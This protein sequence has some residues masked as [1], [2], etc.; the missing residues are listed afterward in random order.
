MNTHSAPK[1]TA[2]FAKQI[3]PNT[4]PSL[5]KK[6]RKAGSYHKLAEEIEVNVSYIFDLITAGREPNDST[7]R[8]REIRHRLGL[9]KYKPRNR[10]KPKPAPKHLIWWNNIG[11]EMRHAIVEKIYKGKRP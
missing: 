3:D 4:L 11:K 2:R 7:P 5:V 6:F 1:G 10:P 8:L 9:R